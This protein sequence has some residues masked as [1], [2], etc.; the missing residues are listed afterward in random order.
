M[1]RLK[2]KNWRISFIILKLISNSYSNMLEGKM[3]AFSN[4]EQKYNKG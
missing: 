4:H 2:E 3:T 1:Y